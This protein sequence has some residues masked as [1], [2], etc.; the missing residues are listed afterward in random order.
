MRDDWTSKKLEECAQKFPGLDELSIDL[1]AEDDLT[2]LAQQG[3]IEPDTGS[4]TAAA[5]KRKLMRSYQAK[6]WVSLCAVLFT[7]SR[8]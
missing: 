8:C 7:I 6:N 5:R 4:N 1:A 2:L 3:V